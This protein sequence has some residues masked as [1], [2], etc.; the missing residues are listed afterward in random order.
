L[1]VYFV[2]SSLIFLEETRWTPASLLFESNLPSESR[3]TDISKVVVILK[4]LEG[5]AGIPPKIREN[6]PLLFIQLVDHLRP[7][8]E[9]ALQS[10]F[11]DSGSFTELGRK[12]L[13]DALPLVNS[14]PSMILMQ[15]MMHADRVSEDQ[16]DAWLQNVAFIKNPTE[17]MI[18][19][20]AV[21]SI[22]MK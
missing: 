8:S 17:N 15:E 12:M 13:L 22:H 14:A 9:N 11:E 18:S 20:L 16:I 2:F 4:E 1:F 6:A 10:L 5:E 19:A 3:E 7:L 21:N